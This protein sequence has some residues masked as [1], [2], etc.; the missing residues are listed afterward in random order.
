MNLKYDKKLF[1]SIVDVGQNEI[2]AKK[3]L[4]IIINKDEHKE[5]VD[6][7]DSYQLIGTF[8]ICDKNTEKCTITPFIFQVQIPKTG[9]VN[10]EG[11]EIRMDFEPGDVV[12]KADYKVLE[13]DLQSIRSILENR[14]KYFRYNIDQQLVVLEELF[15]SIIGTV[16]LVYFEIILSELYRCPNDNSKPVRLCGGD[17]NSAI[18]VDIKKAIHIDG[19]LER[20]ISYGYAKEALASDI[21]STHQKKKDSLLNAVK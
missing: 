18:P 19:S 9:D 13:S 16:P 11:N 12:I 20:A 6:T 7:G 15:S 2:I 5:L 21:S 17:Y 8:K 10:A 4:S 1:T 3:P 14:I